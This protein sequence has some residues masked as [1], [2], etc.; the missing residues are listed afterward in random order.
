MNDADVYAAQDTKHDLC[1]ERPCYECST[2]EVRYKENGPVMFYGTWAQCDD[3]LIK[4]Y[5]DFPEAFGYIFHGLM[6]F[7]K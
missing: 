4:H 1:D 5:R 3:Y 6:T 2:H 7:E